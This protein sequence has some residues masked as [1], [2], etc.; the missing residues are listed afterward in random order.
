[1]RSIEA[2]TMIANG[3]VLSEVSR[4]GLCGAG[5]A[6]ADRAH[7]HRRNGRSGNWYWRGDGG[8]A[9]EA[10]SFPRPTSGASRS[11]IEARLSRVRGTPRQRAFGRIM[12]GW[13]WIRMASLA[14]LLRG[15]ILSLGGRRGFGGFGTTPPHTRGCYSSGGGPGGYG[16]NG[17]FEMTGHRREKNP[18]LLGYGCPRHRARMLRPRDR[19]CIISARTVAA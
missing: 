17:S 12:E 9:R 7:V 16:A 15:Q 2:E 8:F 18:G 5:A 3:D 10:R 19:K 1:M 6:I 4:T 11:T 13:R 14:L